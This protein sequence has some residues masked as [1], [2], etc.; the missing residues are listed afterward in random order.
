MVLAIA[1]LLGR[2]SFQGIC[3]CRLSHRS[4]DTAG[5]VQPIL[6]AAHGAASGCE[7]DHQ[8]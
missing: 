2:S 7:L 5:L 4:L 8:G 3:A 1:F 6:A